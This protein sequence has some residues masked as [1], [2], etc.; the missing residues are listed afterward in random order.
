MQTPVIQPPRQGYVSRFIDAVRQVFWYVLFGCVVGSVLVLIS[1]YA[2]VILSKVFRG[3]THVPEVAEKLLEHVGMGF[4][5]AALAVL[6]YEWGAHL[7]AVERVSSELSGLKEAVAA[8]A[9]E[10]AL[11]VYVN[12]G[13]GEHD[14]EVIQAITRVLEDLK[15]LQDRGDWA[16]MGFQRFIA[17][18]IHKVS[19]N[20]GLLADLS[21]SLRNDAGSALSCKVVVHTPAQLVDTVLAEQVARLPALGLYRVVTNPQ[22]WQEGQF[23]QLMEASKRAVTERGIVVRRILVLTDS[24][25]NG[26]EGNDPNEINRILK[27]HSAAAQD[28]K[29]TLPGA[30]LNFKVLDDHELRRLRKLKLKRDPA[31]NVLINHFAILDN[32]QK[33]HC[34][35]V[36]AN[37]PALSDFQLEGVPRDSEFIKWFDHVWEHLP[38]LD[39]SLIDEIL[40]RWKAA[41]VLT[42]SAGVLEQHG[43]PV[44]AGAEGREKN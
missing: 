29:S 6:F 30:G 27:L 38:Q 28:S 2:N 20:A 17:A 32:P 18:M 37:D 35:Q 16:Q 41:H 15:Q 7:K 5:V 40:S 25:P 11:K 14:E 26:Y 21:S 12:T 36:R 34:L 24:G 10:G 4:I 42:Q 33:D 1:T 3:E 44:E 39:S 31:V 23:P 9:L 13:D 43:G 19:I 8:Q 22:D